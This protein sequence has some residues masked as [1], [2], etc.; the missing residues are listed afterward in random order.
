[1]PITGVYRIPDGVV[2]VR[3]A[4][5]CATQTSKIIVPASVVTIGDSAFEE[6]K[7]STIEFEAGT[8]LKT[9]GKSAFIYTQNIPELILPDGVTS[10]GGNM[11]CGSNIRTVILPSTTTTIGDN[12]F[13]GAY[14]L[15]TF[16]INATTPPTIGSIST[17]EL[18]E[19]FKI[20]VPAGCGETYKSAAGWSTV[21]NLI[22]ESA[23]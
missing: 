13:N 15:T 23:G 18:P 4:A 1:M 8:N 7:M 11:V 16:K 6:N 21:A 20:V 22:V 12:I 17:Y 3:D 5:F 19:D 14:N 2:T 9:V 10:V